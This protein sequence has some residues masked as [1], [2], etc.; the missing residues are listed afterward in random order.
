[1]TKKKIME[2]YNNLRT[3]DD[4]W[5]CTEEMFEEA[6]KRNTRR[7]KAYVAKITREWRAELKKK[8]PKIFWM[9]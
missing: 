4:F 2:K 5:R 9:Y 3:S 8:Y 6:K 7:S 1:M